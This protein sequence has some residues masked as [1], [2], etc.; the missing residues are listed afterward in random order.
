[1]GGNISEIITVMFKNPPAPHARF[2]RHIILDRQLRFCRIHPIVTAEEGYVIIT[3]VIVVI[4]QEAQP[5]LCDP[6]QVDEW[7]PG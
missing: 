4:Q 3:P 5:E 2:L 7:H 1:M 6:F